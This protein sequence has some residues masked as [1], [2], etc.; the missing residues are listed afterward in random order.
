MQEK[1]KR[2]HEREKRG[3]Y[4]IGKDRGVYLKETKGKPRKDRKE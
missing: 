4:V 1:I 2:K 3:K